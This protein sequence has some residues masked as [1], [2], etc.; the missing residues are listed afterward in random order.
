MSLR[1]IFRQ[2]LIIG[3][4]GFG[5]PLAL[6]GLM[7]ERIVERG[8]MV[9]PED[10]AQGVALGNMLPGPVAVSCA[11]H[12]GYRMR[13]VLGAVASTL[14]IVGPATLLMLVL[15]PLYL[16]YGEV[17]RAEAFFNG[18][19]AAVVAIIASVCWRMCKKAG[20]SAPR[21]C[22]MGMTFIL[23]VACRTEPLKG[24]LGAHMPVEAALIVIAAILGMAFCRPQPKPAAPAEEGGGNG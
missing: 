2:F 5:G 19:R 24:L 7:E 13:G 4:T 1:R 12:L 8:K 22:I 16:A 11:T 18:T 20:G 14:G 10:F 3:S 6:I 21:H 23:A 15:T 9:S 17:P